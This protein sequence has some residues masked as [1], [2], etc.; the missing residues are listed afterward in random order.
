MIYPVELKLTPSTLWPGA[1]WL[2]YRPSRAGHRKHG[3]AMEAL[4]TPSVLVGLIGAGIQASRTPAMHEQEGA[5][6]GLRYLYKLI[7][8]DVL[9]LGAA[10]LPELITA[11]ERMGF[12]GLNVTYPCK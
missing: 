1:G 6:H 3:G 4:K 5:Q 11:A 10:A 8:L 7:D 9:G 2:Q 12:A